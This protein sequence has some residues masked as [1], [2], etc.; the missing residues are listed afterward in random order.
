M[1]FIVLAVI[2]VFLFV[3]TTWH[4]GPGL[5]FIALVTSGL[6]AFIFW[7]ITAA[8]LPPER[9]P[10]TGTET[11]ALRAMGNGDGVEG[12]SYFLGSGYVEDKAVI[13]YIE[14][15]DDGGSK[16]K[17][18][19]ASES[20]IYE[21][22]EEPTLS[23]HSYAGKNWWITPFNTHTATKYEFRVPDGTVVETYT[24]TTE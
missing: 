6:V 14:N 23:I 8:C 3:G 18:A 24:L 12:R 7:A 9:V 2:C 15:L 4:E 13:S 11:V 1:L 20:V 10:R 21:G 22:A 16:L 19:N 17:R 5:G